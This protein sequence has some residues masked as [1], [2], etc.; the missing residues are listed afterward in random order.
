MINLRKRILP[1]VIPSI[2]IIFLFYQTTAAADSWFGAD[3]VEHF[4]ISGFYTVFAYEVAHHHF[5][6]SERDS[7]VFAVGITFS[8]GA[9]KEIHDMHE[10]EETAS[11]KDLIVDL[12]GIAAG[13]IIAAR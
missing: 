1:G 12:L 8:M 6:L 2:L 10:P 13:I 4:A 5:E 11:V 7:R 9:A 3:K